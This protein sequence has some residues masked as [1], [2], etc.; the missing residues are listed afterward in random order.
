MNAALAPQPLPT[1]AT[2]PA[3]DAERWS[4]QPLAE[5]TYTTT[6]R[7]GRTKDQTFTSS[8]SGEYL[9][10]PVGGDHASF[11]EAVAVASAFA[12]NMRGTRGAEGGENH[13]I[14]HAAV[15]VLQASD[16]AFYLSTLGDPRGGATTL[17]SWEKPSFGRPLPQVDVT[18]KSLDPSLKALVG[19]DEWINFSSEQITPQLA[20]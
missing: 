20:G 19:D 4:T 10:V 5:T 6:D 14:S 8:G 7:K 2:P 16:G 12:A 13:G 17:D 3:A 1:R 18:V 9:S 15:A 11:S